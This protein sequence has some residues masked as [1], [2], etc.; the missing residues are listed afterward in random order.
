M[1]CP[2]THDKWD[3]AFPHGNVNS[4]EKVVERMKNKEAIVFQSLIVEQQIEKI[5]QSLEEERL[6]KEAHEKVEREAHEKARKEK[7]K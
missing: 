6:K 7:G 1:P 2:Y 5:Q 3:D 4:W